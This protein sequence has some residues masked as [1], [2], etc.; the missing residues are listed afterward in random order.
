MPSGGL[1]TELIYS[2]RGNITDDYQQNDLVEI[3][4]T[5]KH[6][7]FTYENWTYNVEV[8][9]EG[10]NQEYYVNNNYSQI[11]PLTSIKKSN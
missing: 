4:F 11:L 5:I 1:I 3:S 10:W 7:T 2:F 8:Y 6:E 9:S